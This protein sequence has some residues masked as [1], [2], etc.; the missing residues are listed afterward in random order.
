MRNAH[1]WPAAVLVGCDA[2]PAT[3]P[4]G[5]V[6]TDPIEVPTGD[7]GSIGDTDSDTG[8]NDGCFADYA[9]DFDDDGTLEAIG[10]DIYDPVRTDLLLHYERQ[11][12]IL[13]ASGHYTYDAEGNVLTFAFDDGDDGGVDYLATYT[14]DET[15]NVLTVAIDGDGDGVLDYQY[16]AEWDDAGRRVAATEDQDGDGL[17]DR[18]LTYTYDSVDRLIEI[19]G[20]DGNDGTIDYLW[21]TT[22]SDPYLLIGTTVID[23]ENDGIVDELQVF[24]ADT[25]GRIVYREEDQLADG[26]VDLVESF[27]YDPVTGLLVERDQERHESPTEFDNIRWDHREYQYDE[28]LRLVDEYQEESEIRNGVDSAGVSRQTWTFAG[29]CP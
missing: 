10:I 24:E 27:V 5:E 7:T 20:D 13:S 23:V 1:W 21:T 6:D 12:G 3:V 15:G 4:D 18:W 17:T 8:T 14:Y 19:T 11:L 2:E 22:F 26:Y 25:A 29:S 9:W 16:Q 28:L